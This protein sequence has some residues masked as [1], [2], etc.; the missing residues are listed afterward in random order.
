[1]DSVDTST[2]EK[3]I[4]NLEEALALFDENP[5]P[6]FAVSL[7]NSVVL[8]YSLCWG[9]I[10]PAL[11]RSLV[12]LDALDPDTV[13][14]MDLS[15]LLRTAAQHGYTTVEWEWWKR[16][17]NARNEMAHA[18]HESV[19]DDIVDLAPIFLAAAKELLG[20]I[21]QKQVL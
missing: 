14:S 20:K 18:Y 10:R 2:L 17:R 21:E 16:F 19:A 11:E 13:R 5:L 8:E 3:T 6:R 7:R 15:E 4:T 9:R 12:R 1:M